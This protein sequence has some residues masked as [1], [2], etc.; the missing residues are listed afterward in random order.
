MS[1]LII[2]EAEFSFASGI[3]VVAHLV[4]V[5]V[6]L[7]IC[8]FLVAFFP[9][10]LQKT[11]FIRTSNHQNITS[12]AQIIYIAHIAYILLIQL[13][14]IRA[15]QLATSANIQRYIRLIELI[16][17]SLGRWKI[18][19]VFS[20]RLEKCEKCYISPSRYSSRAGNGISLV[21]MTGTQIFY[22]Q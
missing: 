22:M 12:I 18:F 9:H 19:T 8:K 15:R 21:D 13:K 20:R 17:G 4:Q 6:K 14:Q 11:I 3:L 10:S 1:S 5:E 2:T 7:S 16:E